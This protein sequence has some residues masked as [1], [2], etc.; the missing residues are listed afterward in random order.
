M[1]FRSGCKWR[2]F[3]DLDKE[4]GWTYYVRIL[5]VHSFF[6]RQAEILLEN[7]G[8]SGHATETSAYSA[9]RGV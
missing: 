2:F 1:D 4:A 5:P 7:G 8:G 3:E 9:D 6:L